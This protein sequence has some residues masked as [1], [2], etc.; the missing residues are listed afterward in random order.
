MSQFVSYPVEND[1][2][3]IEEEIDEQL[4]AKFE[5]WN[6][7]AG[8]LATWMKKAFARLISSDRTVAAELLAGG[9]KKFGETILSVP[10]I[11]AASATGTSTWTMVDNAG[12]TITAGTKVVIEASGELSE[13]FEVVADVVI[14]P[15][16]SATAAGEVELRAVV[17]GTAA[18]G[19]TADPEPYDSTPATTA[20]DTIEL[21][22]TTSGGVDEEDEDEY[23]DRLTEETQ[24]LS[25]SLITEEDFEKDARSIAGIERAL[26]IGGYNAETEEDEQ[27]LVVTVFP[28]TDEGKVLG[29]EAKAVL[30]ER[31][32]AKVPTGVEVFVDDPTYTKIDVEVEVSAQA[33]YAAVTVK[34][35]VE[36]RLSEYLSP[37]NWGNEGREGEPPPGLWRNRTSVYFYE[38][39]SEV[40]RVAGVDRVVSL[41]LAKNGSE[42]KAENVALSGAAPLTEPDTLMVKV[43]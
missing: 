42:L 18:N 29:S 39:V 13:A 43:A 24:L 21:V 30:Q 7:A 27:P 19:L 5:G 36:A 25:L 20:T 10:P 1:P 28:V 9:F 26:A 14:P 34:A 6:P 2:G 32:Q 8:G 11:L 31:Q 33:G 41:K 35:A 4:E 37:A 16:S 22:G 40:D 12:Y 23:L 17:P 38:L 3:L 15:G